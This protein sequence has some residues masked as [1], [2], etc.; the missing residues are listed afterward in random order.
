MNY[1]VLHFSRRMVEVTCW[2]ETEFTALLNNIY[3][4]VFLRRKVI[5]MAAVARFA[6]FSAAYPKTRVA[7]KGIHCRFLKIYCELSVFWEPWPQAFDL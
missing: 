5:C 4:T 6:A 1:L 7:V 3:M 2:T